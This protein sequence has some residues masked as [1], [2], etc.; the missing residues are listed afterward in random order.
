MSSPLLSPLHNNTTPPN[1]QQSNPLDLFNAIKYELFVK[2]AIIAL[3]LQHHTKN[4]PNEDYLEIVITTK[5]FNLVYNTLSLL[6]GG[7]DKISFS[8]LFLALILL[9]KS[10]IDISLE[11]FTPIFSY[12]GF[13]I[14]SSHIIE[15]LRIFAEHAFEELLEAVKLQ[16]ELLQKVLISTGTLRQSSKIPNPRQLGLP[17]RRATGGSRKTYRK[18]KSNKK[19]ILKLKPNKKTLIN[20]K[21]KSRQKIN[22]RKNKTSKTKRYNQTGGF[23]QA[24][25]GFIMMCLNI[26]T[27]ISS[28]ARQRRP[29]IVTALILGFITLL[30][31]LSAFS[32]CNNVNRLMT[33]FINYNNDNPFENALLDLSTG[34]PHLTL[35]H[36]ELTNALKSI[37]PMMGLTVGTIISTVLGVSVPGTSTS[38]T[39]RYAI[40]EIISSSKFNDLVVKLQETAKVMENQASAHVANTPNIPRIFDDSTFEVWEFLSSVASAAEQTDNRFGDILYNMVHSGQIFDNISKETLDTF[41]LHFNRIHQ[42]LNTGITTVLTQRMTEVDRSV[43]GIR[44]GA[45]VMVACSYWLFFHLQKSFEYERRRNELGTPSSRIKRDLSASY[46]APPPSSAMLTNTTDSSPQ[47]TATMSSRATSSRAASPPPPH[48]DR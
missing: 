29:P 31:F 46:N 22:K 16:K 48:M 27:P 26:I 33:P 47:R 17:P 21:F 42:D 28:F 44:V 4:N 45:I 40:D 34:T 7:I 39:I 19:I 5:T 9:F 10:G 1:T 24:F 15:F 35:G 32:I 20:L 18:S 14:D 41:M 8:Y 25:V 43:F 36:N 2:I 11:E 38:T 23:I 3:S 12:L 13:E 30:F 37:I 6:Y